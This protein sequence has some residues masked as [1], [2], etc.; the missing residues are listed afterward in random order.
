MANWVDEEVGFYDFIWSQATKACANCLNK[1]LFDDFQA[2]G[3]KFEE[4]K[5]K[6]L[7]IFPTKEIAIKAFIEHAKENKDG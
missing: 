6:I 4:M 7:E 2:G 3:D 1:E 5:Q